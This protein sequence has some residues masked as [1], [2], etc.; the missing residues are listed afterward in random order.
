MR[1]LILVPT[2]LALTIPPTRAQVTID[3]RA[4]DTLPLPGSQ[5]PPRA[6]VGVAPIGRVVPP[7]LAGRPAT[8]PSG[9]ATATASGVYPPPAGGPASSPGSATLSAVPLPIVTPAP[10][11]PLA[12]TTGPAIQPSVPP[13]PPVTAGSTTRA[14]ETP[15]GMRLTFDPS[16]TDLSTAS[17]DAIKRFVGSAPG[18]DTVSYNILAYAAGKADD[19]SVARRLSLSRALAVRSALIAEGIASSRIYVRALGSQ[20]GG[21]P[22]DRV[23]ISML[24]A[25]AVQ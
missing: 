14:A 5:T 20:A 7:S 11:P 21:G 4:L 13:P 1:I 2:I 18:A 3:L 22:P 16:S 8:A 9:A 19:A 12:A 24:G 25:N 17:V 23:D 15:A 6:S 10:A